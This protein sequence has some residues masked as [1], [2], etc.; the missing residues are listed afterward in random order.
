MDAE[1]KLKENQPEC[2]NLLKVR[3]SL[4]PEILYHPD[5]GMYRTYGIE[6]KV[7]DYM[8]ILHDISICENTVHDMVR[9][10]NHRQVSPLQF[11]DIVLD[12]LP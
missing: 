11:H 6:I 8:D 10:I 7:F 3:Y 1:M 9:L 5:V 2:E 12:M 4:V